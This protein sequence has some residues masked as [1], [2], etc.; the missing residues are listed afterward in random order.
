[1]RDDIDIIDAGK[2]RDPKP[3]PARRFLVAV[4][5]GCGKTNG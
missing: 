1:M 2:L 4:R 5:R 3:R